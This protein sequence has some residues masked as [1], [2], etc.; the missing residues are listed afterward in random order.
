MKK[1]LQNQIAESGYTLLV[2]SLYAVIVWLLAGLIDYG[3]WLQLLLMAVSAYL[4]VELSNSNM[5]IRVRSRM[6]TSTYLLLSCLPVA[7]FESLSGA[8]AALCFLMF[9]SLLFR[10]YQ[11]KKATGLVYYAFLFLGLCSMGFVQILCFLPL[12]WILMGIR[13][14]NLSWQTWKASVFGVLTPYWIVVPWL[15]FQ[16]DFDRVADHFSPLA[17]LFSSVGTPCLSTVQ[18][19]NICFV[20]IL[21]LVGS[22]HFWYNSMEEKIRNRQFFGFFVDI[23]VVSLLLLFLQPSSYDPLLRIM[24]LCASPMV[25]HFFVLTHTRASNV[26]FFVVLVLLVLLEVCNLNSSLL[27]SIQGLWSGL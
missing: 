23:V 21:F 13:I 9:V 11:D 27:S 14:Q 26:T 19:L 20:L 8:F 3:W 4:M 6:V 7:V 15:L 16:R 17:D 18:V 22:V 1:Y 5:L 25:A 2:A 10:T 12:F 24:I